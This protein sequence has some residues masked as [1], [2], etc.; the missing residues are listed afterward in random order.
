MADIHAPIRAGS[1]IAFLGGLINYVL[2]VRALEHRA[3]LPGVRRQLHQRRHDHRRRVP[4][5]RGP[6]RRLLGPHGVHAGRQG[7]AARRVRRPVRHCRGTVAVR[8]GARPA[9]APSGRHRPGRPSTALVRSLLTPPAAARRD[10]AASALRLPDRAG[11]TSPLHAGDGRAGHRLP[12]GDLPQGGRDDPGQL[13]PRPDHLVRLRRGVDPA[14]LRPADDRLLRAAAA[15]ARQHRP[16]GR[17][18][19]GAA[20]PRLDPGL[21]RHPDALPLDPRLHDPPV[22]A[23]GARHAP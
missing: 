1:D 3:V 7:V 22:R 18:H 9:P 17:R 2:A 12:A 5:H 13:R 4:G 6:R 11:G 23:E 15:P 19:H 16:A 10:A 14:H 21:H 20:R 8:G